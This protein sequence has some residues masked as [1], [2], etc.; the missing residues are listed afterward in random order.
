M[1]KHEHN[2][3]MRTSNIRDYSD[4]MIKTVLIPLQGNLV[5]RVSKLSEEDLK[6]TFIFNREQSEKTIQEEDCNDDELHIIEE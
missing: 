5:N 6:G 4:E 2:K 3:A 1:I